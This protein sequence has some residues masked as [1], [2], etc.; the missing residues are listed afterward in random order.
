V[1]SIFDTREDTIGPPVHDLR[2][3]NEPVWVKADKREVKGKDLQELARDIEYKLNKRLMIERFRE[4]VKYLPEH[5]RR[6]QG[7]KERPTWDKVKYI[8]NIS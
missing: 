7:L 6:I 2:S 4:D 3:Y 5:I 8:A 1:D